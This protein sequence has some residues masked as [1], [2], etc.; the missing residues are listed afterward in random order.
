MVRARRPGGGD[1]GVD[2][3][4]VDRFA[5]GGVE[6]GARRGAQGIFAAAKIRGGAGAADAASAHFDFGGTIAKAKIKTRRRRGMRR[7]ARG[8]DGTREALRG[9]RARFRGRDC[10]AAG[11]AAGGHFT[12]RGDVGAAPCEFQGADFEFDVQEA[13]A[14]PVRPGLLRNNSRTGAMLMMRGDGADGGSC[15]G[16]DGEPLRAAAQARPEIS[17][18]RAGRGGVALRGERGDLRLRVG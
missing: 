16:A 9:A 1:I 4:G 5:V 8:G 15:G 14:G 7:G 13:G 12:V 3:E 18:A 10:G 11:I 6:R 2:V 17:A